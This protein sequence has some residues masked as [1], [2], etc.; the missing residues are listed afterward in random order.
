MPRRR[1]CNLYQ[2]GCFNIESLYADDV[3][4]FIRLEAA[5]ITIAMDILHLVDVVLGL[6]TNIQKS[7]VLP[8]ICDEHDLEVVHHQLPCALSN[9][10]CKYLS[11]PLALEEVEKGAH[12]AYH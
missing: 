9:F 2:D 12:T 3:F 7:N 4:L 1:C 8:I 11:I 6:K 5:D 10:P